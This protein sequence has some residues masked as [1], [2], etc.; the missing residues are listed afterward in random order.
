MN[1]SGWRPRPVVVL[2][3]SAVASFAACDS[4]RNT[5]GGGG[6]TATATGT[7]TAT[8]E[9]ATGTFHVGHFASMTGSEATF[10][11]STDQGIKLAIKERNAAIDAGTL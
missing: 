4:K 6:G 1:L 9:P 10:G 7:G 2:A 11:Q 8:G 3:L 5:T